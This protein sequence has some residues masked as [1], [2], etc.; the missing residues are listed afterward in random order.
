MEK[1]LIDNY[2]ELKSHLSKLPITIRYTQLH[3]DMKFKSDGSY[4]KFVKSD[5]ISISLYNSNRV[6]N[7]KYFYKPISRYLQF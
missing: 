7:K 6:C 4:T 5:E 1:L 2:D 3:V